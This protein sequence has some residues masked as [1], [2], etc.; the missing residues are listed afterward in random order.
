MES[1]QRID[2][3]SPPEDKIRLFRSLFRGRED[4]YPRRFESRRTGK[5][6]YSPACANEWIKN[7]CEKPKVKCSNCRFQQFLPITDDVIRFHLSGHDDHGWDFTMGIYPMLLDETCFFVAADFD[8][9]T[10][11]DDAKAFLATCR[12]L[13]IP[14]VLER[15]RSGNGG[16]I[17]FFFEEAV[18]AVLARK[19]GSYILT[20]T[21][22]RRPDL[23]LDS[24]DR[25]F[26]NQDTLPNGGFGSL[27]AL[28]LQN[29]PRKLGNSVFLD[30]T[31]TP[32]CDQWSFRSGIRRISRDEIDGIVRK[33]EAK[34][35][36]VGVRCYPVD[37]EEEDTLWRSSASPRVKAIADPLPRNLELILSNEI[38][39]AKEDLPPAL[40]NRLV[41]LAA[42]QNPE[43]Y[44]AQAMR[45]PTYD[46]P[47]VVGCARDYPRHL[48]LPR[49]CQADLLQTLSDLTIP[50]S[51]RDERCQG[52]PLSVSF[53]GELRP[54]QRV[55][56]EAMLAHETGVLSATT[57]FGKTVVAAWIIAQRAVN[58][59]VLVHRRQLQEQWIEALSR[60]LKLP[61][62]A[63]G[64]IGGGHKVQTGLIDVATIQSLVK[65]GTVDET[66]AR[67]GHLVVDECHH[68]SAYSFEQVARSAKARFVTGLS[69]TVMR[70]DGHHPIIFMQCGPVRHRVDAKAQ[71]ASRP[72]DHLVQVRPTGFRSLRV[73][74]ADL[75][76]QYSEL[77]DELTSA[78]ARTRQICRDVV[79]AMQDGRSPLVLTE[80]NDHLDL[81]AARLSPDV[82]HVVVLRG[83]MGSKEVAKIR[84][85]LAAIPDAEWRILLATGRYAGEGFDDCRLDT[86]FLTLPVSWR[87][88]IAQYVGRLHR[89]HDGKREVRVY[90]YADLDVPMLARMFD[91]R[92]KGYEAVGYTIRLPGSAMPGWPS[93][94]ELPDDSLWKSEYAASVRR[95]AL[96]GVDAPLAELFARAAANLSTNEDGPSRAR[97]AGEQFLFR[98]LETLPQ[99]SGRFRLNAELPIPFDGWGRMEVDLLCEAARIAVELDGAQ[100]LESTEA[101]RRDR[102]KDAVLQEHGYLVLRFLAEDV[103]KRLDDVLH[104]ILRALAHRTRRPPVSERPSLFK[105]V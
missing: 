6:G 22:E 76:V 80:R 40:R 94:I 69:A 26:P 34:G 73:P 86:L 74:N 36:V 104:G 64:R 19:L 46:T 56:A 90:D 23:G 15:S 55:A 100:H 18:P 88:T 30:D 1:T 72:F 77:M 57:A 71:A 16:H 45:L 29:K 11:L 42:F 48:G 27:I 2:R 35:Q 101:Y 52:D 43:F 98:R 102:H 7:V 96:D 14:A 63:I 65:K 92:C 66:I 103:T 39:I 83:G 50:C 4:V 13:E 33:A 84:A 93:E 67:Y 9:A 89:L 51:T 87:G 79:R 91:R 3:Y 25:L 32:F 24:Y 59:L 49:G 75:R 12:S 20:E 61:A 58:T 81:L 60:F 82:Q 54:E 5:A 95:L 78:D 41:R 44:R 99:T 31:A 28:P 17:W 97:S 70:K 10:W 21:M 38:Y 8:K 62:K 53:R 85:R 68:L 47:R 105:I 37:E